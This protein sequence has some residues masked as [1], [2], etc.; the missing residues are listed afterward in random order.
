MDGS[1]VKTDYPVVLRFEGLYPHQ[2]GGYEA[3]RLRKGGDL[4]HVDRSRT[5]LNGPPLIGSEDWAARALDEIR[6]MTAENFAAELESLEKRNRKKDIERRLVEGP[7]PP[8]RA[9]RHGPMREVILTVN[10]DWFDEDLSGFFGEDENQRE[11]DF[12]NLAKGWLIENFG[13]D[14]IHARADRDE[15]A[16]HIHAVI[17]PRATVEIAKP[18]AKVPT[19]TATRRML[20]PSIHPLIK[21]Y[22]AAQDSVGQWFSYLGLVRGE[23]RAAAIREARANGEEPPKRRYHAKTWKWR[24]EEELRLKAE[25]KA[26]QT[27]SAALDDRAARVAEREAEAETVLAVAEGV[28]SGAFVAGVDDSEPELIDAIEPTTSPSP[29]PTLEDLRRKSPKGVARASTVFARAWQR[30]FGDARARA[31]A[32]AQAGVATAMADIAEADE[33][34]AEAAAHL[35]EETRSVVAGIRRTIPAILRRLARR[36]NGLSDGLEHTRRGGPVSGDEEKF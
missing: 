23:R 2:L 4:S 29:Q 22:E 28:T 20:Q 33:V 16:Y 8:W 1:N 12:E 9:T 6:D 19:A 25:A 18:K 31:E 35:P 17:L 24:A 5:K 36:T 21:D 32:E 30:L 13:D 14:V 26:L 11:K 27:D 15:A 34:I 10:K 7:K 3:H